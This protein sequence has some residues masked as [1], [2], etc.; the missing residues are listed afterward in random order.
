MATSSANRVKVKYSKETAWGE[1]PSA[2]AMTEIGV[3]SISLTSNKTTATD[4]TLRSDRQVDAMVATGMEAAGSI[5]CSFN[6]QLLDLLAASVQNDIVTHTVAGVTL[7]GSTIVAPDAPSYA[8][9]T[10]ANIV[11]ISGA[12]TPANNGTFFITGRASGT[13]TLTVQKTFTGSDTGTADVKYVRNGQI[14]T[15]FLV[16]RSFEDLGKHEYFAGTRIN[17]A[18]ID[19]AAQQIV[20]ATFAL[21]AKNGSPFN[22]ASIAGTTTPA[23]TIYPMSASSNVGYITDAAGLPISTAIS[24]AKVNIGNNLRNRPVVGSAYTYDH[25]VGSFDVSIDAQV[26]FE[27]SELY[28]KVMDN[29]DIGLNLRL[30]DEA[31]VAY[32]ISVPRAKIASAPVD[33]TGINTDV[34]QNMKFVG[35]RDATKNYTMQIDFI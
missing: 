3:R 9:L 22:A 18:T 29:T 32:H 28:T 20:S 16:E 19:L 1:T 7:S 35:L 33:V 5:A 15:S 17:S 13:R 34:Q 12:T 4:P 27:A 25:G 6:G 21:M 2:P 30:T 24:S 23:G 10:E 11:K 14:N 26:Y 31:G 8:L